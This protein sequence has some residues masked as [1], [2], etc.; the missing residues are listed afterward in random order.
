MQ[1]DDRN[2]SGKMKREGRTMAVDGPRRAPT[3]VLIGIDDTDD[4]ESRGTGN[5]AQRLLAA[6]IDLVVRPLSWPEA[7]A[8]VA[9]T[10]TARPGN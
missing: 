6:A 9:R 2:L 5:F 10:A 8:G 4:L 1:Q 7:F 3:N